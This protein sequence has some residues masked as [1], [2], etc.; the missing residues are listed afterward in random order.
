VE[1]G[2]M[3]TASEPGQQR[4]GER[5]GSGRGLSIRSAWHEEGMMHSNKLSGEQT[6]KY[7][8]ELTVKEMSAILI[9]LQ[10]PGDLTLH[11]ERYVGQIVLGLFSHFLLVF[12]QVYC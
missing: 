6:A 8:C 12:F 1:E 5:S 9:H 3:T 10:A 11:R 7:E 4:H 2:R